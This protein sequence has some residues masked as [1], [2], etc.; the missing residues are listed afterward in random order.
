M[1]G[2]DGGGIV[3]APLF[4]PGVSL[5]AA[6]HMDPDVFTLFRQTVDPRRLAGIHLP[7]I[8][9]DPLCAATRTHQVADGM[10]AATHLDARLF[11]RLAAHHSL[12]GLPFIYDA[13]HQLQQPGSR[14]GLDGT[15]AELLHQH[16]LVAHGIIRQQRGRMAPLEQLAD[17]GLIPATGK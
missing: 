5:L 4:E 15:D 8:D 10:L 3:D 17:Y 9:L 14:A 2:D 1:Q 16:Y 6:H 12:G 7:H 11:Y 13:G